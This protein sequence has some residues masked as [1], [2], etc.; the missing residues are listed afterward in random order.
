MLRSLAV[1]T[2][3]AVL[4]AGQCAGKCACGEFALFSPQ[5]VNQEKGGTSC[6]HHGHQPSNSDQPKPCAHHASA[7]DRIA[8]AAEHA[9]QAPTA[10]VHIQ[11]GTHEVG[12]HPSSVVA[13]PEGS[14]PLDNRHLSTTIL[15]I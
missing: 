12:P 11:L 8:K 13:Y 9:T 7:A 10:L 6:H 2:A 3:L 1:L 14:P 5:H 4:V 15:R